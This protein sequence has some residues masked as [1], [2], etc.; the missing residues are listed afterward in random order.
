MISVQ[1]RLIEVGVFEA[2]GGLLRGDTGQSQE[3]G[4]LVSKEEFDGPIDQMVQFVV[5]IAHACLLF[6]QG[7]IGTGYQG[8]KEIYPITRIPNSSPSTSLNYRLALQ[9]GNPAQK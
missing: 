4:G 3:N 9:T 1:L 8:P 2:D 7:L 5:R 6:D